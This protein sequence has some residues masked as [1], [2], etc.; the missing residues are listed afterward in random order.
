MAVRIEYLDTFR[1]SLLELSECGKRY[2]SQRGVQQLVAN[3][4]KTIEL[5]KIFP[6]MGQFED[7]LIEYKLSFRRIVIASHYKLFYDYDEVK[8]ILYVVDLW[9]TRRDL[10][11]FVDNFTSC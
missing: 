4:R 3:I 11:Q 7:S 1:E 2:I 5:L 6:C 10:A 9:D 8:N